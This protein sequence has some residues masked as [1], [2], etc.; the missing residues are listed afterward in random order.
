[1]PLTP[2]NFELL[3]VLVTDALWMRLDSIAPDA[4]TLSLATFIE[5]PGELHRS[6]EYWPLATSTDPPQLDR[7]RYLLVRIA[8]N[9]FF[10][11]PLKELK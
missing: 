3:E 6:V 10:Y 1:M 8:G 2:A 9:G 11:G 7:S 5:S 4:A